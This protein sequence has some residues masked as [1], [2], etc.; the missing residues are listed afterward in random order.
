MYRT[1]LWIAFA[2]SA[3]LTACASM[4]QHVERAPPRGKTQELAVQTDPP[5]AACSISRAGIEIASV[6]PTPGIATVARKRASIE[7]TCR[8]DGFLDRHREFSAIDARDVEREAGVLREPSTGQAIGGVG[9]AVSLGGEAAGVSALG[10]TVGAIGTATAVMGVGLALMIAGG[11]I[12][13][14]ENPPIAFRPLPTLHL[15]RATFHSDSERDAYFNAL[16][17][18]LLDAR[19]AEHAHVDASCR[20]PPCQP[21]DPF[22]CPNPVCATFHSRVDEEFDAALAELPALR[23]KTRVVAD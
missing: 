9:A 2:T 19:A 21:T 23:A 11:V 4:G 18:K 3:A 10:S 6:D 20:P 13:S 5:G 12:D 7:I 15:V 1:A 8:K 17:A 16:E 22:V 14:A